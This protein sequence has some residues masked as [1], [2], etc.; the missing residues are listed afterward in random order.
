MSFFDSDIVS[1]IVFDIAFLSP[2]AWFFS[3]LQLGKLR[4]DDPNLD[5]SGQSFDH[6]WAC[7]QTFTISLI[8][9]Q[10]YD[11]ALPK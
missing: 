6:T 1:F 4:V 2:L 8:L 7:L 5:L 9:H 3:S 11:I 10:L